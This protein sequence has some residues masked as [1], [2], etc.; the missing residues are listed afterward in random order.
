MARP[1]G[2]P[3]ELLNPTTL[4]HSRAV[5]LLRAGMRLDDRAKRAVT[6]FTGR[7]PSVLHFQVLGRG[8]E[9]GL[10]LRPWG[11]KSQIFQTRALRPD[12]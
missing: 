6:G 1:T 3:K 9:Y 11:S 4:R 2:L 12:K 10:R 8:F 5:E 7:R